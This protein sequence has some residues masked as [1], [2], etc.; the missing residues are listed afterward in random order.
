MAKQPYPPSK[1]VAKSAVP[2][3]V[4]IRKAQTAEAKASRGPVAPKVRYTSMSTASG[5]SAAAKRGAGAERN[6]MG[7]FGKTKARP[8]ISNEGKVANQKARRDAIAAR[9]KATAGSRSTM[10]AEDK[11]KAG[12]YRQGRAGGGFGKTRGYVSAPTP[13]DRLGS[14]KNVKRAA[15]ANRASKAVAANV[16]AKKQKAQAVARAKS[17]VSKIK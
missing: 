9:K 15:N 10:S 11:T 7:G 3:S 13:A 14:K 4:A 16:A 12:V 6:K 2:K 17:K 8:M 1:K 5:A